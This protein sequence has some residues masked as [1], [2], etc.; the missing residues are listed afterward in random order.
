MT[1]PSGTSVPAPRAPRPGGAAPTRGWKFR[2]SPAAA[3][4]ISVHNVSISPAPCCF[5]WHVQFTGLMLP[6]RPRLG[7]AALCGADTCVSKKAHALPE[8]AA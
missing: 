5:I 7:G 4:Y 8:Q 1:V 3:L 2:P 6:S